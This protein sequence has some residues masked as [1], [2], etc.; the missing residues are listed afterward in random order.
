[1][2]QC[3]SFHAL[4][5]LF[6]GLVLIACTTEAPSRPT[7][8][9]FA[10]LC[11]PLDDGGSPAHEDAGSTSPFDC[12]VRLSKLSYDSP[13][14]DTAEFLELRIDGTT[15][16]SQG[17]PATLGDCGL[18]GIE[19]IN[20]A[21]ASCAA[22]RN[23]PVADLL[24]PN[25]GYFV[26]CNSEAEATLGTPC[27]LTAWGTSR[28]SAGWLQNGPNDGIRLRGPQTGHY[29]YEGTPPLC[30][31][32]LWLTLPADTGEM[33]AGVDDVVALCGN[34]YQRLSLADAP[35]RA[36]AQCPVAAGPDAAPPQESPAAALPADSTQGSPSS[37]EPPPQAEGGAFGSLT[38]LDSS[39]SQPS[40]LGAP[41]DAAPKPPLWND[42][43]STAD[44]GALSPPHAPISPG[45]QVA[46]RPEGA[47]NIALFSVLIA[48]LCV[49]RVRATRATSGNQLQS[50]NL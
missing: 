16:N 45:C 42:Y 24:V 28:L 11:G 12:S 34:D 40:A 48:L 39:V 44:A 4:S 8:Q 15:T 1:M 10:P 6:V 20:G 9:D 31:E 46:R 47:R 32:A 41:E 26:L 33:I 2:V 13:G 36:P 7:Q 23:I 17:Q 5:S 14:A 3:R 18:E 29:A 43:G 25:D 27:D 22:Y 50:G 35:L 19:L 21:E 38:V 37:T 49:A 30:S